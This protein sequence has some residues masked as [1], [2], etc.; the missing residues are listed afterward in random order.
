MLGTDAEVPYVAERAALPGVGR[1]AFAGAGGVAIERLPAPL[2]SVVLARLRDADVVTVRDDATHAALAAGGVPAALVPDPVAAVA[3]LFGPRIRA[4]TRRRA[5]A[6][7]RRAFAAGYVAVQLSGESGDDASLDGVA[8]QLARLVA[9][10]GLGIVTWRAGAAPWHDDPALPARLAGRLGPRQ[11]RAFES[12]D[13]WDTCA[14]LA[15]ARACASTSLHGVI[16]ASAFGVPCAGLVR[17]G[18]AGQSAKLAACLHTWHAGD[19][20]RAWPLDRLAEGVESALGVDAT[21]R[22][23]AAAARATAYCTAFE[24]LVARLDG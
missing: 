17:A 21:R 9:R 24:R 4:R 19:E 20:I 3:H 2:Q 11:A 10:T 5:L 8:D 6:D 1:I 18:D 16:V 15:G 7:L 13:V 14:L 12:L 22:R 23:A